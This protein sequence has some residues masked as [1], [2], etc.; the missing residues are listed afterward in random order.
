MDREAIQRFCKLVEFMTVNLS[1]R[2]NKLGAF[3]VGKFEDDEEVD[4]IW[5]R[6]FIIVSLC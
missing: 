1:T 3:E 5:I 2:W 6:I 4:N